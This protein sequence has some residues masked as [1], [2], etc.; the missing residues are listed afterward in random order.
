MK[1]VFKLFKK[2]KYKFLLIITVSIISYY[3]TLY[4]VNKIGEIVDKFSLNNISKSTFYL[5]LIYLVL[6]TFTLYIVFYIKEYNIFMGEF[7]A[8]HELVEKVLQKLFRKTSKFFKELS[9]SEIISIILN[10]TN[11]YVA[12]FFS[13]GLLYFIEGVLYNIYLTLSIYRKSDFLLTILII[14]PYMI[15]TFIFVIRTKKQGKDYERMNE[16]MDIMV[17][18]TL[19]SIKGIRVVRAYNMRNIVKNRFIDSLIKYTNNLKKYQL[20]FI[21]LTPLINISSLFSYVFLVIYGYYLISIGK[22]SLGNLISI[23]IIVTMLSWPYVALSHFIL[24][25]KELNDGIKRL[26]KI[27]KSKDD[28][29]RK[30][31]EFR[32]EIKINDL[33]FSYENKKVLENISFEIKKGK[34]IGIVG[35][36]G[37]GKTTLIK[38]ILKL[39][40]VDK[41]MILVDGNDISDYDFK[42]MNKYI[43]YVPQENMLFSKT[44]KENILFYRKEEKE[45]LEKAIYI[46]DLE[47]DL[48]NLK[49]GIDSFVGE[50]G[51]SLSGGQKQRISLARA[52]LNNPE[53]LILDDSLSAV[54]AN[55]EKNILE[56]MREYRKDKTNII[57]SH[58]IAAIKESDL[59]IIMQDG[60]IISKGTHLELL[61]E[62]DWYKNLYLYQSKE[63]KD[64]K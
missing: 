16:S 3:L 56:R 27:L 41:N 33:S 50:G 60:K 29:K 53:I 26:D 64:E 48:Q 39:Y 11:T 18:G 17:K 6:A 14:L 9:I 10:D 20:N 7:Y 28:V 49:K 21:L 37:S 31:F 61:N 44:I 25:F 54:D 45:C 52:L 5:E 42:N 63:D 8:Q 34:S 38:L 12:G 13:I 4:S 46:S 36:T 19:E 47:K 59:I 43:S 57:I 22:M 15:Q 23:S 1:E 58:R 40:E 62:N 24:V 32:N 35:K 30:E 51:V 55:T 2:S